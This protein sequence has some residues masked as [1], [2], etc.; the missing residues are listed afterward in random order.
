MK[1]SSKLEAIRAYLRTGGKCYICG[2]ECTLEADNSQ[3]M[4]V[5]SKTDHGHIASCA[6]CSRRRKGVPLEEYRIM[7]QEG[8][9]R[10]VFYGETCKN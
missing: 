1:K 8:E 7:I 4:L 2:T 10:V 9:R 5:I 6:R 3:T